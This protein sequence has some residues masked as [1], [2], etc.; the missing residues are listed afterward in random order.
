MQNR[1]N[2]YHTG[3]VEQYFKADHHPAIIDR[4]SWN[5]TQELLRGRRYSQKRTSRTIH[6]EMGDVVV[7]T[8]PQNDKDSTGEHV[9]SEKKSHRGT[10]SSP[11][12][13]MVCSCC[14]ESFQ[15]LTYHCAANHYTDE[16]V[17]HEI[18][19]GEENYKDF[20]DFAYG[21]WK[22]KSTA[23]SGT[24]KKCE[25]KALVEFSI[26]QSFMEMLYR[27][28]RDYLAKGENSEIVRSFQQVYTAICQR[29]VNS[30]FIEQKLELLQLD[31]E[32][33]DK[34]YRETCQKRETAAYAASIN[35]VGIIGD[36]LWQNNISIPGSMITSDSIT[37]SG[38]GI[39]YENL[40]NDLKVRLE[41]KRTEYR[42][43]LEE[44]G[45]ATKLKLNLESF[46]KALK[47]LPD[48][49]EVG[50]TLNINTL[51]TNGSIFRTSDGERR[52]RK[53]SQY[54]QGHLKITQEI[55]NQSPD[56]LHFDEYYLTESYQITRGSI[57]HHW[58]KR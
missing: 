30:G 31:I 33:L 45:V 47:A 56:Y 38:T 49:N 39:Q 29:E 50:M 23:K 16:R 17:N 12:D 25:M 20:F 14:G 55:I 15:R 2:G 43:L 24:D 36:G 26:E 19:Q 53:K 4:E 34:A 46:L 9:V 27:I 32:K 5:K 18:K 37:I 57:Q 10:P 13:G 44:R 40:A 1:R 28:K 3:E 51:D 58:R 11:F 54:D 7:E 48:T 35:L 22:C 21:V 52:G 8:S 42:Q 41:E 6:T